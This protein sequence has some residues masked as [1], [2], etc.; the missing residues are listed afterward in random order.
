MG[1]KTLSDIITGLKMQDRSLEDLFPGIIAAIRL[2]LL[3]PATSAEAE[4]AFSLLRRT[5]TWLRSTMTT[6]R[7]NSLSLLSHHKELT[8]NIDLEDVGEK[9]IS[10]CNR[11]ARAR[12]CSGKGKAMHSPRTWQS[13]LWDERG[14]TG[15]LFPL[16]L[17]RL[18]RG[19][20]VLFSLIREKWVGVPGFWGRQGGASFG[21]VG[22]GW[23][24]LSPLSCPGPVQ[25]T[26]FSQGPRHRGGQGGRAPP[27]IY[28]KFEI[29]PVCS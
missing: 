20:A 1:C 25:G 29:L 18:A 5:K 3:L 27:G 15:A 11:R 24:C 10:K 2:L 28:Q 7:L 19:Q 23:G 26:Q 8:D 4:R 13:F 22:V 9:F 16:V 6:N 21:M 17:G 12:S 14:G